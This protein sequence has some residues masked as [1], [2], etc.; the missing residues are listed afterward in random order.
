MKRSVLA[1]TAFF[2]LSG[3]AVAHNGVEHMRGTVTEISDK[4]ITIRTPEKQTKMIMLLADTRFQSGTAAA[5]SKDVKVGDRVVVDV[6]MKGK[7]MT[8]KF[9]KFGAMPTAKST[10]ERQH[11]TGQ[12]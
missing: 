12:N 4:A 8:A 3:L 7:D 10:A 11:K 5:T 2:S 9:V 1:L 6:V